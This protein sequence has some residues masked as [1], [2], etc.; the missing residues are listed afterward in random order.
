MGQ[1][2]VLFGNLLAHGLPL[3]W[4]LGPTGQPHADPTEQPDQWWTPLTALRMGGRADS[5]S[6]MSVARFPETLTVL[7]VSGNVT[8]MTTVALA[9]SAATRRVRQHRATAGL[10]RVEVEVPTRDDALAVRRFAQV[11]RRANET[12]PP[13]V[14]M[15]PASTAT[16]VA[17]VLM[18]MD[19]ARQEIALLFGRALTQAA[20]PD[21]LMRGR[22]VALNFAAAVA[23]RHRDMVVRD[24][25]GSH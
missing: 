14:E 1:F 5:S 11:R 22:R 21:M 10:I 17:A 18:G 2:A 7:S 16:D 6:T 19:A 4:S 24:D 3:E 13:A 25:D 12:S 20:D 9:N 8:L 15:L 23:Q